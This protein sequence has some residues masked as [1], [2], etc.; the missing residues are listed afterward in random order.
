[1]GIQSECISV[2]MSAINS[3]Y[4]DIVQHMGHECS[5]TNT[6]THT[7]GFIPMV[8]TGEVQAQTQSLNFL[9][10]LTTHTHTHTHAGQKTT[11]VNSNS[12]ECEALDHSDMLK[13]FKNTL[14]E[15]NGAQL[16]QPNFLD[17]VCVTGQHKH[18]TPCTRML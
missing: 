15:G 10:K 14:S 18:N 7:H 13:R 1:M 3:D 9:A 6:H 2:V 4:R 12:R 8:Y 16:R 11:E 17:A 5:L